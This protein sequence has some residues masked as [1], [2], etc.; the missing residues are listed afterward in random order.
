MNRKKPLLEEKT[1][2]KNINKFFFVRKHAGEK[3]WKKLFLEENNSG[4][5]FFLKK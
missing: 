1:Q 2:E 4:T 5:F 3:N